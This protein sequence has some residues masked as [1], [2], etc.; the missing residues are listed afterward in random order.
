MFKHPCVK[1]KW[2]DKRHLLF[3]NFKTPTSIT[4]G[5]DIAC[6]GVGSSPC[7]RRADRLAAQHTVQGGAVSAHCA[8]A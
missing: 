6:G 4:C 7:G 1:N 8:R 2:H 5:Q 3:V